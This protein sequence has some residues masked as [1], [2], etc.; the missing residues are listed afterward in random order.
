[1]CLGSPI[2]WKVFMAVGREQIEGT[3]IS[4]TSR[5]STAGSSTAVWLRFCLPFRRGGMATLWAWYG[6]F[7]PDMRELSTGP[8]PRC[9]ARARM[10]VEYSMCRWAT[11]RR[12]ERTAEGD[13][14]FNAGLSQINSGYGC[15]SFA[16]FS[17]SVLGPP[18]TGRCFGFLSDPEKEF[19]ISTSG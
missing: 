2:D 8:L 5:G 1:M 4:K 10:K 9:L 13:G 18:S 7:I 17:V 16:S 12:V 14:S 6:V 11:A 15:D 19:W 3:V